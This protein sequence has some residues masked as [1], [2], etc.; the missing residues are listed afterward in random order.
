MAHPA[1][2]RRLDSQTLRS[3]AVV[4]LATVVR[5]ADL[6]SRH[7]WY[8][9][10][11]S[12]TFSYLPLDHLLISVDRYDAHPPLYYLQLHAWMALGAVDW[13]LK[14]NSVC[15]SVLTVMSLLWIGARVFDRQVALMSALLFALSPFAVAYAQEVRM[16]ALLMFMGPWAFYFLYVLLNAARPGL[17]PV[18]GLAASALVFL[19]S[20]GAGFV[21]LAALWACVGLGLLSRRLPARRRALRVAILLLTITARVCALAPEGAEIF[22]GHTLLPDAGDV[23]CTYATIIAGFGIACDS[24]L[25]AAG[26]IM[27]ALLVVLA[28][29]SDSGT[30]KLMLAFVI[31]PSLFCLAASYVFRPI[32][33]YR[34]LA[35]QLPF[36]CLAAGSVLVRA[37]PG[38]ALRPRLEQAGAGARCSRCSWSRPSSS[39]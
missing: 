16:Y 28:L 11:Q 32:W 6:P 29:R 12:A 22:V 15:W 31:A 35:F 5:V 25:A 37:L 1:G 36:M 34:T 20:H 14:A 10:L 19:Y 23:A 17:G 13:W 9:E 38:K 3:L 39:S 2:A 33:L 7:L 4:A 27:L 21:F 8:D 26:V 30:R 18:I 24:A